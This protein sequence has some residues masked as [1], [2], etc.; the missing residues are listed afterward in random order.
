M[1]TFHP[2]KKKKKAKQ[3]KMTKNTCVRLVLIHFPCAA[4]ILKS[5]IKGFKFDL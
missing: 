5:K 2:Q 3:N 4:V 1:P